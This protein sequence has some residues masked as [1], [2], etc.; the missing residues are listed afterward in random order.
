MITLEVKGLTKQYGDKEAVEN[1]CFTLQKGEILGLLGL[2]G[3]GKS[4]T[5]NMITGCLAPTEGT[6]LIDG[7]DILKDPIKAKSKI[8]YLPELPPLYV[9]MRVEEYLDFICDVKK[10]KKQKKQHVE[11]VCK[12]VGIETVKA[13][14]IKNLSKGYKQRVGLAGALIGNPEILILDEPTV[15]LDPTQIIEIRNLIKK[16]GENRIIILSSHILSEI[17]SVC[18]RV[19]VLHKGKVVADG[20]TERL[21]QRIGSQTS[22]VM[23]IEGDRE[24]VIEVL[25]QIEGIDKVICK[26][27]QEKEVYEYQIM[28]KEGK[29]LRRDIFFALSQEGLPLLAT[30]GKGLS[31]EEIFLQLISDETVL[32]KG[33]SDDCHL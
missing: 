3:A 12:I 28:C 7:I 20:L 26:E 10:V 16:M 22:Y 9:D 31:L 21:A 6:V 14:V 25:E 13:R 2:N 5:M 19:I 18:K 23:S 27:E 11:E 15:G 8:G 30:K 4:T 33:A 29:D 17:Q 24:K 1:I 32:V